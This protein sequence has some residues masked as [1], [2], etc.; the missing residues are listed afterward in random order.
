MKLL[1]ISLQFLWAYPV[2]I[3]DG[4]FFWPIRYLFQIRAETVRILIVARGFFDEQMQ[5]S[6]LTP[7]LTSVA[8]H[9]SDFL[10]QSIFAVPS[11]ADRFCEQENERQA[12]TDYS[13]ILGQKTSRGYS[14]RGTTTGGSRAWH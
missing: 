7:V 1:D 10:H 8:H 12:T 11:G 9:C 13:T 5:D 2:F 14:L 6:I 4:F 3:N